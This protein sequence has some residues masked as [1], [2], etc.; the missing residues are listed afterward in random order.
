M[1]MTV[2]QH[3]T[4]ILS[5]VLVS[6]VKYLFG[7]GLAILYDYGF[8][9]SLGLTTSGGIGGTMV[10]LFFGQQIDYYWNRMPW[11]RN[12]K[13]KIFTW[14]RRFII[15]VRQR[16]GL[17]IIALLTPVLL[18]VPFGVISAM[19]TGYKR[20]EIF[21]A[22]AVSFLLWGSVLFGLY[23]LIGFD[24]AVYLHDLLFPEKG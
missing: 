6:G 7:V 23:H 21:P 16:G 22:M 3:I 15:K 10:M 19:S 18:T 20:H 1:E 12:K 17:F 2:I 4:E 14:R 24:V 8:W 5:V 11:R 13:R 9:L